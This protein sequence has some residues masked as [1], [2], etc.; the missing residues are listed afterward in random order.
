MLMGIEVGVSY[1]HFLQLP[2]KADLLP[3]VFIAVQTVL[4]RYKVGMSIVEI[5]AM[6][7]LLAILWFGRQRKMTVWLTSGALLMVVSAFM[8]WAVF[9]EP[10]NQTVHTWTAA[11][12]PV[13][14]AQYR[15]RWH[16]YHILRL[17]TVNHWN[18]QFN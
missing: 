13:N 11:S 9:I 5:G 3:A 15:D 6:V 17:G 1:S 12:F 7:T 10:I 18:E 16:M 14:W 8:V 2:G 4:I